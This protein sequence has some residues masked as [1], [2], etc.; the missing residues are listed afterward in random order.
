MAPFRHRLVLS[1]LRASA[2]TLIELLVVIA[3]IA[4]LAGMLLPTLGRAREKARSIQCLNNLHQLG[5]SATMY[6]DDNK[7]SFPERRNDHRWPTQLRPGYRMLSILQCP[8]DR[9]N[10]TKSQR[11]AQERDPDQAIRSFIINGWNDYYKVSLGFS[12]ADQAMNRP[13]PES[14]LREPNLT[15][16]FGEKLTNSDH[17]YMDFLEGNDRD[18]IL[19]NMHSGGTRKNKV[20]GSNYAFADGHAEFLKYRG[21]L[22]PLNLWAVTDYFRTNRALAN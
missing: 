1:A 20:G 22:Y 8:N 15:I 11:T 19:R 2:F 3:I 14:A 12:S 13:M 6:V 9:R 5:L 10:P 17:F 16:V 4:I 7:G 18:Q 21:A